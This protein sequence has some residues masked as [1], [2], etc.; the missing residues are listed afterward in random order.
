VYPMRF[1]SFTRRP[2]QGFTLV[3]ILISLLLFAIA[4]LALVQIPL[5]YSKLMS[6][7]V[8]KENS[9]LVAI[10]A[11][12]YIETL[13]YEGIIPSLAS[14]IDTL[15]TSIDIPQGYE[16]V[17]LQVDPTTPGA[18]SRTISITVTKTGGLEKQSVTLQRAVSPYAE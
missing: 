4:I 6:M 18:S 14:E 12:D 15:E 2:K 13:D 3:E 7:S 1:A 16:I 10:H 17:S 5:F 9:T 8:E 11:L